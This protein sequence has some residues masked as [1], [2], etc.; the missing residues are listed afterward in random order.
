MNWLRFLNSFLNRCIQ[1]Q[2][3]Y[4][5]CEG[6]LIPGNNFLQRRAILQAFLAAISRA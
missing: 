5:G 3:T 4:F 1:Q 6:I 2:Q